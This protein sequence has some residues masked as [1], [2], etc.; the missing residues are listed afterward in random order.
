MSSQVPPI[1]LSQLSPQI[2]KHAR[3][4]KDFKT[5]I[6]T[7]AK[8]Q[9]NSSR[10]SRQ[11]AQEIKRKVQG[12]PKEIAKEIKRRVQRNQHND[13]QPQKTT[14]YEVQSHTRTNT[15]YLHKDSL[16][17]L[18]SRS[19]EKYSQLSPKVQAGEVSI[20]SCLPDVITL[21]FTHF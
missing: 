20:W 14:P 5:R 9:V 17:P 4:K 21:D 10:R 15:D 18:S 13:K 16:I 6:S 11:I 12:S 2:S 7:D 19:Y 1:D 8:I 3:H